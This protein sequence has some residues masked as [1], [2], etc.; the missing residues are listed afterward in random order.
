[1]RKLFIKPRARLDLLEIWHYI[2]RDN[3]AAAIRVGDELDAAIM[4]LAAMPGKGHTRAE[5]KD[6]R[7][8]FW[9]V[10]SY[11]IAYRF[12]EATITVVRVVHGRRNIRRLI[13]KRS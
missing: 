7:V 5:V 13:P 6:S 3:L 2:A 11:L 1:M 12:D 9:S 4:D 10:Y 8:R